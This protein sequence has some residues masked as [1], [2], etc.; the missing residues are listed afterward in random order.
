MLLHAS[1]QLGDEAL[2]RF[3]KRLREGKRG[4]PL[5][6]R[7]EQ[8]NADQGQAQ[9]GAMLADDVV[10]QIFC[11]GRQ[12]QAADAVDHHQQEPQREQPTPRPDQRPDLRQQLEYIGLLLT[13]ATGPEP[14]M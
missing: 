1:A 14:T 9:V 12:D 13:G 10:H 7:G 8:D 2:G 11:G 4:E 6:C 3:G 5:Y